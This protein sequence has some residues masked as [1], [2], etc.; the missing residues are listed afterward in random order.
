VSHSFLYGHEILRRRIE[1]LR[2]HS[3]LGGGRRRGWRHQRRRGQRGAP[4]T[5]EITRLKTTHR[6][7]VAELRRAL[8]QTR[9]ENLLLRREPT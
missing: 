8:E 1:Q 3:W 6:L 7:Q 4:F 2:Q 5:A 9:R